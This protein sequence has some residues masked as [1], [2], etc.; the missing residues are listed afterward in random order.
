LVL[1]ER[2]DPSG[3]FWAPWSLFRVLPKALAKLFRGVSTPYHYVKAGGVLLVFLCSPS[4]ARN[5]GAEDDFTFCT[6]QAGAF[7]NHG[8]QLHFDTVTYAVSGES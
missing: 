6:C 4:L 1:Q 8:E 7:P 5:R 3:V 2:S